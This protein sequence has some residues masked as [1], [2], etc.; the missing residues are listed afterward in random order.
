MHT[1]AVEAVITNQN[2]TGAPVDFYHFHPYMKRPKAARVPTAGELKD[3][4][5]GGGKCPPEQS[6]RGER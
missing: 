2:R 6:G 4:F 5:S 1:G 3:L